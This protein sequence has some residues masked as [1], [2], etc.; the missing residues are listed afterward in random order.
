L[1]LALDIVGGPWPRQ[2]GEEAMSLTKRS[3]REAHS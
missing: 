3:G 2:N 1:A